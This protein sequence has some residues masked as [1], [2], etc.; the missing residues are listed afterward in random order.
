MCESNYYTLGFAY[1]MQMC[2]RTDILQ[3]A[4]DYKTLQ[5]NISHSDFYFC[6]FNI[7]KGS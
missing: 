1:V 2:T 3:T 7:T 6:I 5:L 4:F